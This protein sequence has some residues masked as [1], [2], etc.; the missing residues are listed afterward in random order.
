[1]LVKSS[2]QMTLQFN[3]ISLTIEEALLQ[4]SVVMINDE[5]NKYVAIK[6][7]ACIEEVNNNTMIVIKTQMAQVD[8]DLNNKISRG[9]KKVMLRLN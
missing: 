7:K 9:N 5:V 2:E 8:E 4:K 1:M 6:M 3:Q